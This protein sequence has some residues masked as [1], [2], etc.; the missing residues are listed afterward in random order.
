VKFNRTCDYFTDKLC[1]W[2]AENNPANE[3]P[4]EELS[5]SDEEDDPTAI[6]RKYRHRATSDDEEFDIDDSGSEGGARFGSG[7][8]FSQRYAGDGDSDE[9][10]Y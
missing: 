1:P 2:I 10:S 4:D 9:D 6:Y 3:Y 7:Y 5:F 8:G